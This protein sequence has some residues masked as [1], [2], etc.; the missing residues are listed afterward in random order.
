MSGWGSAGLG[1]Q[2]C[3]GHCGDSCEGTEAGAHTHRCLLPPHKGGFQKWEFLHV[4]AP[5]TVKTVSW[6]CLWKA[7]KFQSTSFVIDP[8]FLPLFQLHCCSKWLEM[9]RDLTVPL[10]VHSC[11]T[12]P[13]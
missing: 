7:C 11:G 2:G 1:Y 8:F 10:T 12:S 9:P 6:F 13:Q 5:I 3:S 4:S